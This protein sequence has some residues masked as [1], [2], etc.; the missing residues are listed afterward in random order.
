MGHIQRQQSGHFTKPTKGSWLLVFVSTALSQ[1]KTTIKHT[2]AK[3]HVVTF[4][5]PQLKSLDIF[6]TQP[7]RNYKHSNVS[8]SQIISNVH[9]YWE[10]NMNKICVALTFIWLPCF[11]LCLYQAKYILTSIW[12]STCE[13]DWSY[14][15]SEYRVSLIPIESIGQNKQIHWWT[16][17]FDISSLFSKFINNIIHFWI[18]N[19]SFSVL[20]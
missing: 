18:I 3:Q 4:N 16:I 7:H 13:H 20:N 17:H 15:I 14:N 1:R 9:F 19:E 10:E 12:S 5:L 8:I 2:Q 6:F 11:H